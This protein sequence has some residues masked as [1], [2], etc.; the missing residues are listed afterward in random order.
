MKERKVGRKN[1]RK[2][3]RGGR[4]KGRKSRREGGREGAGKKGSCIWDYILFGVGYRH[5]QNRDTMVNRAPVFSKS[6]KSATVHSGNDRR[7]QL[8]SLPLGNYTVF[9]LLNTIFSGVG[10]GFR[11]PFGFLHYV[12]QI[13]SV[14][15]TILPKQFIFIFNLGQEK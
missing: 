2:G 6:F 1:K 9:N 13:L 8:L 12:F 10:R 14:G 11:F 3:G 4:E 7:V 5:S 15:F